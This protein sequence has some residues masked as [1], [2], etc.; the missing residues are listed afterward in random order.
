MSKEALKDIAE[1]GI[2]T[3]VMVGSYVAVLGV[4]IASIWFGGVLGLVAVGGAALVA[5]TFYSA[6]NT[7]QKSGRDIIK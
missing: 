6:L 3:A 7:I 1:A 2:W 4:L 5:V